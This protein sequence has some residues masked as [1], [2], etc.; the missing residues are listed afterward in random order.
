[1][2]KNTRSFCTVHETFCELNSPTISVSFSDML[3]LDFEVA[4]KSGRELP[5][6]AL[7]VSET[8]VVVQLPSVA[9]PHWAPENPLT[10]THEQ[11]LLAE[12]LT[13]P[14]RHGSV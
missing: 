1:V 4:N 7:A 2:L 10:Q 6:V 9:L 3:K 11:L 8:W 5:T 14:F 12:T 13:P